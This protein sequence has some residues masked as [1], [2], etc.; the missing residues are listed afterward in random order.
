MKKF[1]CLVAV[2]ALA[3]CSESAT[4][5]PVVEDTT[6]VAEAPAPATPMALDGQPSFGTFRATDENDCLA[7]RLEP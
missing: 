4:E 5:E 6:A 2:A 1:L 7:V 3:A